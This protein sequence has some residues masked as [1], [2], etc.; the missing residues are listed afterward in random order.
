MR[1]VV[2]AMAAAFGLSLGSSTFAQSTGIDV[3]KD[4]HIENFGSVNQSLY[5]GAQPA[6]SDY[7]DLAA[8]GIK[9][10]IDLEESGRSDEQQRVTAAGMKFYRIQMSD[11][12]TPEPDKVEEFL[13]IVNNPAEQPV[14]VHC[15]GG[16]HRTG[17][18]V[19]VYRMTHDGW[20]ADRAYEEM[21]H[22]RFTTTFGHQ[23]LKRFVD[24]Y[25]AGLGKAQPKGSGPVSVK[26]AA[27][28]RTSAFPVA[29]VPHWTF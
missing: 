1:V 5:R 13:K 12:A 16:R 26:G 10:V 18:M 9:T 17:A 7:R 20:D 6:G 4:I 8:L 23:A 21:R 19:A 2:A 29:I 25:Y 15:H 28:V 11:K 22:Y 14:F 24:A 3:L 27:A